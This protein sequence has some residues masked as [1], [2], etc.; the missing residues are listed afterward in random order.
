[1][2]Q[3][4]LTFTTP[5]ANSADD[6][7]VI[8]FFYFYQKQ[9]LTFHANCPHFGNLHEMSNPIFWHTKNNISTCR[10]MKILHRLLRCFDVDLFCLKLFPDSRLVASVNLYYVSTLKF[11]YTYFNTTRPLR[12]CNKAILLF[13]T[14]SANSADDNLMKFFFSIFPENKI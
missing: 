7:L 6:N 11:L 13:T 10:L 1:M 4:I 12:Q 5:W 14:L 9:Y 8:F 3:S 2:Q